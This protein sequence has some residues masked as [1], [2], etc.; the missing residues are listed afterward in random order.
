MTTQ[1][2]GTHTLCPHPS[3]AEMV[4]CYPACLSQAQPVHVETYQFAGTQ[5]EYKEIARKHAV[6]EGAGFLDDLDLSVDTLIQEH[7]A[8][9]RL[10]L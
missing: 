2:S 7:E 10:G 3:G 6:D 4:F 5:E 8:A 1:W 9:A